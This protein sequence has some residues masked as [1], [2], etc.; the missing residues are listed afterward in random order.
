MLPISVCIIAKN[1]EEYVERCLNSIKPYGFEIVF[2]D[3]GSTDST[4]ELASKFTNKIYH[5]VWCDDFS[6]ARNLAMQKAS[7]PWIFSIDCDESVTSLDL[8]ALE[9]WMAIQEAANVPALGRV[10]R[11]NLV[12]T[13]NTYTEHIS[14]F[15]HKDFYHFAGSI[16]EQLVPLPSVSEKADNT[17][18]VLPSPCNVPIALEHFGYENAE[19]LTQKAHRNIT[20]LLQEHKKAPEDSYIL[21]Q[22]GQSYY[23]LREYQK[24]LH[25]FDLGL[26]Q[27]VNPE[28]DY[29]Q[30]MVESY[31]YCLLQQKE[32][33][34]ALQL[35]NI[36]DAFSKRADFV[37]LM[38]LIYMNN[39]L[40]PEA[41][42]CFEAATAI[43]ACSVDGVNS[44]KAWYNAGVIH[45]CLG[46]ITQARSFYEKA[47]PYEAAAARLS[48]LQP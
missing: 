25:Y 22:L 10:S 26:A 32:Y 17:G 2:V 21:F 39:G 30:N 12:N 47:L 34:K 33:K 18:T 38:G 41:I 1:E 5:F 28:E 36:Y 16:H 48:K 24:A 14:R 35:E 29:V 13:Q 11:I 31:G 23:V 46:N 4:L 9:K 20:L 3:T 40:F 44:Y 6:A 8:S 7:N 15:F 43:P 45:E 42:H 19:C 37:F 27:D